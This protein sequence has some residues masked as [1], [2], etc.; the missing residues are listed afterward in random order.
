MTALR[1][2]LRRGPDDAGMTLVEVLVSMFIF[3]LLSTGI[4]YTMLSVLQVSRDARARQVAANLAAQE[5]DLARDT[6]DLFALLDDD[7]TVQLNGDNFRVERSTQW[8]SDP[9][10]DFSCGG[11]GPSGGALR[12]KRVN[13]TVTWEN[14]RPGTE[15]VRSDTVI[16][17]NVRINDPTRGTILVSVL[18]ASGTGVAGVS[19]SASPSPGSTPADTDAQGCTYVLKAPPAT[20]TV[21]VNE[22]GYRD[23]NQ[24]PTATQTVTV[25][26]GGSASAGFLY[27]RAA[28][29]TGQLAP[30][31]TPPAGTLRIP[32]G[33]KVTFWNTYGRYPRSADSG[34]NTRTPNFILH[35]YPSGYQAFAGTCER[36]E[37]S[38][39]PAVPDPGGTL[40][41]LP[42]EPVAA[43]PGGSATIP[44]PMGIVTIAG[45]GSGGGF[46]RAD[47]VPTDPSDPACTTGQLQ[48]GNVLTASPT[49]IAL[50]YGTW[51]LYRSTSTTTTGGTQVGS[52]VLSTPT[53]AIPE[54]TT[55]ATDGT[56]T[57]DPRVVVP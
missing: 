18:N 9:G 1:R 38:F 40:Q 16:D 30:G 52:G 53:P 20:Y 47:H 10:L 19:V 8:V 27:D 28:T 54:R 42:V 50:P 12:Y 17:P 26:A 51:R 41:S 57:L 55:V 44:V 4:V 22:P 21:S 33:L 23:G 31:Y 6:Q 13:V 34:A 14:M 11:G 39:W 29:F 45:G 35:P 48:F 56:I 25:A 43:A 37:P 3:A 15:P 2:R 7:W 49:T 24:N 32:T 46:L 5:I 36:A